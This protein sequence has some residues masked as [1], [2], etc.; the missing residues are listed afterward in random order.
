MTGFSFLY[1]IQGRVAYGKFKTLQDG[2]TTQG[3]SEWQPCAK[4]LSLG[5]L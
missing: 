2:K 4:K 1:H 5:D 3:D